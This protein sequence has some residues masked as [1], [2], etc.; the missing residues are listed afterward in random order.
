MPVNLKT[1]LRE[2]KKPPEKSRVEVRREKRRRR[3]DV[4]IAGQSDAAATIAPVGLFDHIEA[5]SV[6]CNSTTGFLRAPQLTTTQRN[7]LPAE[8]GMLVYNTTDNKIQVYENGAWA[9]LT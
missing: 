7:A 8:N 6:R 2:A 3:S 9:N 4:S 1:F 5:E